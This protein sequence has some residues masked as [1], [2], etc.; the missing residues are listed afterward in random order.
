MPVP[1][2]H[3]GEK[4]DAFM[5]RCM[6]MMHGENEGKDSKSKRP[7]KQMVAIC[8]SQWKKGKNKSASGESTEITEE[9]KKFLEGFLEKY[10]EYRPYFE[11]VDNANGTEGR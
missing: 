10:P 1:M 3:S 2:P 5:S 6:R 8:F 11:E 4:Q 7:Q 9:D